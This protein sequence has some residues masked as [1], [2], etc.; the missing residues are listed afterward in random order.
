M[1]GTLFKWLAILLVVIIA[2]VA[3]LLI[4]ARFSD[5]PIAIV[6]GGPF[7]SGT[8]HVGEEPDWSSLKDRQ[9]VEFQLLSPARSRTTWIL[10]HN[11][12]IYIPCGYMN[13]AWGKMWKQWPIEAEDDGRAILRVDDQLYDRQLVRVQDGPELPYLIKE[14]SR[15]YLAQMSLAPEGTTEQDLIDSGLA[16]VAEGSLWIFEMAPRT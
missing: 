15:K 9:E 2:G 11:G 13:T 6:A 8:P 12:R 14:I 1:I 7:T 10:E 16:Q 3:V 4:G 5:G